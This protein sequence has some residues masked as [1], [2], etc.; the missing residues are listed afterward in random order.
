MDRSLRKELHLGQEVG[1]LPAGVMSFRRRKEAALS[2]SVPLA[3]N[4]HLKFTDPV[5]DSE[6]SPSYGSSQILVPTDRVCEELLRRIS[7]CC[8]EFITWKDPRALDRYHEVTGTPKRRRYEIGVAIFAKGSPWAQRV[9]VSYQRQPLTVSFTRQV[10]LAAD[11]MVHTCLIS[12]EEDL[13]CLGRPVQTG[14]RGPGTVPPPLSVPCGILPSTQSERVADNMDDKIG[15]MTDAELRV[16]EL[17]APAWSIREPLDIS[18]ERSASYPIIEAVLERENAGTIDAATDNGTLEDG[19]SQEAE[20]R[21]SSDGTG[22]SVEVPPPP[23]RFFLDGRSTSRPRAHVR[24][25]SEAVSFN[26]ERG[27]TPSPRVFPLVPTRY[28]TPS[29]RNTVFPLASQSVDFLPAG[30]IS[31]EGMGSLDKT[32]VSDA[33]KTPEYLSHEQARTE[34]ILKESTRTERPDEPEPTIPSASGSVDAVRQPLT[35]PA[36]ATVTPTTSKLEL[37]SPILLCRDGTTAEDRAWS[38]A[39]SRDSVCSDSKKSAARIGEQQPEENP[40]TC[41]DFAGSKVGGSETVDD[42]ASQG[43]SE[44]ELD[45]D[46]DEGLRGAPVGL[47]EGESGTAPSTPALSSGSDSSPRYSII[48]TPTTMRTRALVNDNILAVSSLDN[49]KW[50][51]SPQPEKDAGDDAEDS[52]FL[53]HGISLK[54]GDQTEPSSAI[55]ELRLLVY[56]REPREPREASAG[57]ATAHEATPDVFAPTEHDDDENAPIAGEPIFKEASMTELP[58]SPPMPALEDANTVLLEASVVELPSPTLGSMEPTSTANEDANGGSICETPFYP[59]HNRVEEDQPLGTGEAVFRDAADIRLQPSPEIRTGPEDGKPNDSFGASLTVNQRTPW[60]DEAASSLVDGYEALP[61]RQSPPPLSSAEGDRMVME[62]LEVCD[63]EAVVF[64]TLAS[65]AT[66]KMLHFE[67]EVKESEATVDEALYSETQSPRLLP[68]K[69]EMPL[70]TDVLAGEPG[71]EG[72]GTRMNENEAVPTVDDKEYSSHV[73]ASGDAFTSSEEVTPADRFSSPTLDE[74]P[75]DG[76]DAD[77]TDGDRAA[78]EKAADH[79]ETLLRAQG[80]VDELNAATARVLSEPLILDEVA[81]DLSPSPENHIVEESTGIDDIAGTKDLEGRNCQDDFHGF[82]AGTSNDST[83]RADERRVA[84]PAMSEPKA[85]SVDLGLPV[86]VPEIGIVSTTSEPGGL[87]A[88]EA[89]TVTSTV[90]DTNLQDEEPIFIDS[91]TGADA[92]EAHTRSH[93]GASDLPSLFAPAISDWL[94]SD[95]NFLGTPESMEDQHPYDIE[96]TASLD[97]PA[98]ETGVSEVASNPEGAEPPT[99]LA[100]T[101]NPY[102]AAEEVT[103]PFERLRPDDSVSIGDETEDLHSSPYE[104]ATA[105]LPQ[106]PRRQ[107]TFPIPTPFSL[108]TSAAS[109]A[110]P[111]SPDPSHHGFSPRSSFSSDRSSISAARDSVDT[112]APLPSAEE[113][114]PHAE[115]EY[116]PSTAGWLGV[117]NTTRRFSMPLHHVWDPSSLSERGSRTSRPGTPTSAATVRYYSSYKRRRGEGKRPRL[118]SD[119][120][121]RP[122]ASGGVLERVRA[123]DD[124]AKKGGVASR[125]VMLFAGVEFAKKSLGGDG[126]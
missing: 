119:A 123:E 27:T 108:R 126:P 58:S 3:V 75:I 33:L 87:D 92:I 52:S 8:Q 49:A 115:E 46:E 79:E 23:R 55:Q 57:T 4:V 63:M 112:I 86:L 81:V 42:T 30:L 6:C 65:D 40:P 68:E 72:D 109:P 26:S 70:L 48:V 73:E 2:A 100:A 124:G 31:P 102:L 59:E 99:Q 11:S 28:S 103:D 39:G 17:D 50:E 22:A 93:S 16:L 74:I 94:L 77:V 21:S 91:E 96:R 71:V 51:H 29:R 5:I 82:V 19:W 62:G 84:E 80:V 7:H 121:S 111:P 54:R 43:H 107:F 35:S 66:E 101:H 44:S 14:H 114:S 116:R 41:D 117:R 60:Y 15:L 122:V 47:G 118:F 67:P 78:F 97:E 90:H 105:T 106:T 69:V 89:T 83:D 1:S 25:T 9:F 110:Q 34:H 95:H 104:K 120:S 10:I 36:A 53:G 32:H 18:T 125:F 61:G 13:R 38:W 45:N 56:D 98:S 20:S 113:D 85:S 64:D 37:G 76:E 88:N 12:F 24:T